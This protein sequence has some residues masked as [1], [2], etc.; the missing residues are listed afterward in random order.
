MP[1][2]PPSLNRVG[3][4]GNAAGAYW[5]FKRA[6]DEWQLAIANGVGYADRVYRRA[7][8]R[9]YVWHTTNR[10]RDE[11]NYRVLLEKAAGDALVARRW[12]ADDVAGVYSFERVHLDV[13]DR[14]R[15]LFVVEVGP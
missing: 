4:R 10:R 7:W 5:P 11:G 12:I 6:K 1:A 9:A 8:V 3:S 14:E 13:G 2:A 15:T